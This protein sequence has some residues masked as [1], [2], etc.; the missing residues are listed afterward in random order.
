VDDIPFYVCAGLGIAVLAVVT[1]WAV[2]VPIGM[3]REA[4][5]HRR[6]ER[7]VWA[8]IQ[9]ELDREREARRVKDR[10]R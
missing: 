4:W 5:Q 6:R 7:R 3:V 1:G 10:D 2:S 8:R 9:A